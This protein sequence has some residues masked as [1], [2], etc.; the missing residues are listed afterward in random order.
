MSQ[1]SWFGPK[2]PRRKRL[3]APVK[4]LIV[5]LVVLG[6]AAGWVWVVASNPSQSSNSQVA[7]KTK[8]NGLKTCK[9][10]IR[11]QPHGGGKETI[12]SDVLVGDLYKTNIVYES[13]SEVHRWTCRLEWA[14]SR[15]RVDILESKRLQ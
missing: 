15:W 11:Q 10:L 9:D 1:V 12:Q 2:D 7:E 4:A 14:G 3:S 13:F 8:A 6:V 5:I